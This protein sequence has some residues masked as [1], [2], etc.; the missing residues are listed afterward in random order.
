MYLRNNL[1]DAYSHYFGLSENQ[2]SSMTFHDAYDY[3]DAVYSIRF[4]GYERRHAHWTRE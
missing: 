1:R 4:H 3:A 2:S